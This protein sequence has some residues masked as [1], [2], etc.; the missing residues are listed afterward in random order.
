MDEQN[1]AGE[2]DMRQAGGSVFHLAVPKYEIALKPYLVLARGGG[3]QNK[4]SSD[5][6]TG[7]GC[8][9]SAM[10]AQ[11]KAV[12]QKRIS[13][14]IKAAVKKYIGFEVEAFLKGVQVS[15]TV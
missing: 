9:V 3:G 15:M 13:K 11:G 5:L 4:S 8:S 12:S 7:G 10:D 6:A 2:L 1:S 14:S